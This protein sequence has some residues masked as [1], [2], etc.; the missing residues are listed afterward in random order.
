MKWMSFL[1]VY[2]VILVASSSPVV[3]EQTQQVTIEAITFENI[4]DSE[5]TIYFKFSGKPQVKIFSIQGENPRLVVDIADSSYLGKNNQPFP[6]GQLATG[7]RIGRHTAP[8]PKIR[9]VVDLSKHDPVDYRYKLTEEE[10]LLKITLTSLAPQV[11]QV[12]VSLEEIRPVEFEGK[13]I[14]TEPTMAATQFLEEEKIEKAAVKQQDVT[15]PSTEDNVPAQ[16]ELFS[17]RF[18]NSSNKGEMILFHLSDFHPPLIS[19]VGKENPRILCEFSEVILGE[20]IVDSFT[21]DGDFVKGVS[22]STIEKSGNVRVVVELNPNKDY[23]LQQV[24]FKN[25]NLFVLIVNELAIE[26][27]EPAN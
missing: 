1:A 11:D 10:H 17:I 8:H 21:T 9:A 20:S 3:A 5:E 16:P 24:F 13:E 27:V 7:V 12:S 4:S 22:V 18:D 26:N 25:D 23:D 14:G 2:F 15:M 19:A 6:E